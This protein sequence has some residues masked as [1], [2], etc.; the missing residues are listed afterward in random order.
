MAVLPVPVARTAIVSRTSTA[1]TAS[2]W[3][4]RRV[5]TWA[6]SRAASARTSRSSSRAGL[7]IV[8][9][10]VYP[11]PQASI[12]EHASPASR[13]RGRLADDGGQRYVDRDQALLPGQRM[14][15]EPGPQDSDDPAVLRVDVKVDGD[16]A[17]GGGGTGGGV[18]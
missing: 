5:S 7:S 1:S 16:S 3:P 18:D 14:G 12:R 10:E 9:R 11:S 4:G 6:A 2:R 15:P 17:G 8:T 13:R